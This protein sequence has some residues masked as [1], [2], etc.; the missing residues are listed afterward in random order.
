[1]GMVAAR[2][3]AAIV[4]AILLSS[5]LYAYVDMF[6]VDERKAEQK[7]WPSTAPTATPTTPQTTPTTPKRR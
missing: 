2:T 1:M 6:L 4:I 5:A 7:K 3:G